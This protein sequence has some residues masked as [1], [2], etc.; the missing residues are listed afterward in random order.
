MAPA[1]PVQIPA[2]AVPRPYEELS[3]TFVFCNK[4]EA[5]WWHSTAPI[6]SRLLISSGY[7]VH[8]QYKYLS[9]YRELVLPALGPYVEKEMGGEVIATRWRS[10]MV[11]TGLPIEFSN[12]LTQAV[13]RIGVEPIGLHAGTEKDPYNSA[14][15]WRYV[16]SLARQSLGVD[17]QRFQAFASELVTTPEEENYLIINPGTFNS[18]CKTQ[19][20]TAMDLQKSG[21]IL[22]KAYFYPQVKSAVTGIPAEKLLINAIRKVDE[23][24]RFDTQLTNLE[25]YMESRRVMGTIKGNN[26][27]GPTA[28][29]AVFDKCSFFPYFLSCDLVEPTKSRIKFYA[30]ER[31]VD[32]QVVTDIWTFSGRRNDSDTL[33]GLGIL[34]V[35]WSYLPVREGFSTMPASFCEVG[36]SAKGMQV[37]MMFHFNLDGLSPYPEPQM[38]I[39]VFGIPSSSVIDGLTRFLDHVGWKDMAAHY[40]SNFLCN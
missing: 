27:S 32:L 8:V 33:A 9:L 20:I 38:Y 23:E 14:A 13:I 25:Q 36:K 1:P 7:D 6:L 22:L 30:G 29:D 18:P 5:Q 35:L 21:N 11:L 10:G 17:L 16:K 26:S 24:K 39:C 34:K 3:K 12:N 37:P 19:T 28:F 2:P 31:Q 4:H 40:K 15:I